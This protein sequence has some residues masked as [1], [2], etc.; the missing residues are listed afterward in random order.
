MNIRSYKPQ[1]DC[2]PR[3]LSAPSEASCDRVLSTLPAT[4]NKDLLGPTGSEGFVKYRLPMEFRLR[5]SDFAQ[6]LIYLKTSTAG[7]VVTVDRK[8]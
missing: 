4:T 6:V 7:A 8:K 5:K 3:P 1:V 2:E